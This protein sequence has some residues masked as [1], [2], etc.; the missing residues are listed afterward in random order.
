[1]NL[2]VGDMSTGEVAY[3]TNRNPT[4]D[5]PAL[6]SKGIYAISNGNLSSSW[7]KTEKGKRHL[8]VISKDKQ[9]LVRRDI[10]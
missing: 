4:D 9:D 8:Q 7:P 3:V 5:K 2:I 1:M 10:L 6:L